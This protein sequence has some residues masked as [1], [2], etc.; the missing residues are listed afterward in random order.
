MWILNAEDIS[1]GDTKL[2]IKNIY[3]SN[4]WINSCKKGHR[5]YLKKVLCIHIQKF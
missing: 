2:D 5:K 4:I 3:H 1:P